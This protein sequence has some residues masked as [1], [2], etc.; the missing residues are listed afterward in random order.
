[1]CSKTRESNTRTLLV[2]H[3]PLPGT[4]LLLCYL[5]GNLLFTFTIHGGVMVVLLWLTLSLAIYTSGEQTKYNSL[6]NFI[7]FLKC[8]N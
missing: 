6:Q 3:Q 7:G 5:P 1:M 4:V 8:F 2:T